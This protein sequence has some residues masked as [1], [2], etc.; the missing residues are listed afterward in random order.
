MTE[1]SPLDRLVGIEDLRRLQARLCRFAS[2]RDWPAVHGLFTADGRFRVF[3]SDGSLA[4]FATGTELGE[5]VDRALGSGTL[6]VRVSCEEFDLLTDTRAEGTCAV[7]DLMFLGRTGRVVHGFGSLSLAY[8]RVDAG[9]RIRSAEY[10]RL[11]RE[12]DPRRPGALSRR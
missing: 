11:A 10:T 5:A 6:V 8:R 1:L 7:E 9:W 2:A 3:G 4:C 12:L